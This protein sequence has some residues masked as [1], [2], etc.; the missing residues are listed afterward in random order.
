VLAAVIF[1][2]FIF[3]GAVIAWSYLPKTPYQHVPLYTENFAGFPS[4]LVIDSAKGE[5]DNY[6]LA[7]ASY[8]SNDEAFLGIKIWNL[9]FLIDPDDEQD[10]GFENLEILAFTKKDG[11]VLRELSLYADVSTTRDGVIFGYPQTYNLKLVH[12]DQNGDSVRVFHGVGY[13]NRTGLRIE[14]SLYMING[15]SESSPRE[16]NLTA[17]LSYVWGP[18]GL[19]GTN[20]ISSS[21]RLIIIE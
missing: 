18:F 8:E 4:E 9:D 13:S 7:L 17:I 1:S 10:L 14:G 11:L 5:F 15:A 6:T 16:L 21:L 3:L 12:R 2:L 19:Y 20:T